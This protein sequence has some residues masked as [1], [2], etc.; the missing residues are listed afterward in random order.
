ELWRKAVIDRL[1]AA[2]AAAVAMTSSIPLQHEWDS[3]AFADL[4]SRPG[5]PP[6]QRP[7]GRVRFATP[8]FFSLMGIHL[9]AGRDFT[10]AD[11]PISQPVAIVNAAFVRRFLRDSDPLRE[12]LAG[13]STSMVD[14]KLVRRDSAIVGVVADVK[15]ASLTQPV[16]PVIYVPPGEFLS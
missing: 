16:E 11:R 5:T 3:T 12:A 4:R 1:R 6:D 7:N 10:D 13:F 2:G 14:G 9:L 8:G 15:Y